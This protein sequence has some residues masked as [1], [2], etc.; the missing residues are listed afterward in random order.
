MSVGSRSYLLMEH[1]KFFELLRKGSRLADVAA[2]AV[3]SCYVRNYGLVEL[4]VKLQVVLGDAF[5][6]AVLEEQDVGAT[7]T[8]KFGTVSLY[9]D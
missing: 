5:L 4:S 1:G 6:A 8:R 3:E 7:L 9:A 2:E